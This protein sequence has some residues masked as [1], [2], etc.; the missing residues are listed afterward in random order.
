MQVL[1]VSSGKEERK[2]KVND[3]IST[4]N[5]NLLCLETLRIPILLFLRVHH[6]LPFTQT[7][8][9][10][11][12]TGQKEGNPICLQHYWLTFTCKHLERKNK[13]HLEGLK[14]TED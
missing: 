1:Y 12:K 7:H 14:E 10:S 11:T 13:T 8:F 3:D 5:S 4:F 6:T 2:L 9:L